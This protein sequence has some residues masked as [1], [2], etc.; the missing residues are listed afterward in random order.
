MFQS[1]ADYFPWLLAVN[2]ITVIIG[3]FVGTV[4]LW[5]LALIMYFCMS[6]LGIT[7]T[8]HRKLAHNSYQC[9]E[10]LTKLFTIFGCLGG[11]GSS[12]GWV[13]VH[14]THHRC[15]DKDGDPHSPNTGSIWGLFISRY[16]FE[17]NKWVVRDLISDPFH[18]FLHDWYFVILLSPILILA[19]ID[20]K[21]AIFGLTIPM[22]GT[23]LVSSLSVWLGHTH[24]YRVA[25]TNDKSVNNWF[26]ALIAHGDGWHNYHHANPGN[27]K[28][29]SKWWEFDLS[30]QIIKL[31]R[32]S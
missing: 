10:W 31:I 22:F 5:I 28:F 18:K 23:M 13:A 12:I 7:V 2:A 1:N 16:E 17:F 32:T 30:Y 27:P 26:H 19:L 3:I 25:E 21:L 20:Y 8:F 24:G 9:P 11:T 15:S 29:G 4:E 14:R 6:C